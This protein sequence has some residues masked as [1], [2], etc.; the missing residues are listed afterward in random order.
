MKLAV[1]AV[2]LQKPKNMHFT[3]NIFKYVFAYTSMQMHNYPICAIFLKKF[4]VIRFFNVKLFWWW[5]T[6][7]HPPS[8]WTMGNI[9]LQERLSASSIHLSPI[10]SSSEI[11]T[12]TQ[13]MFSW[14]VAGVTFSHG[15]TC[16]WHL[17]LTPQTS[18]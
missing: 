2:K 5:Q 16:L 6:R 7:M 18:F 1:Y 9:R 14:I 10:R 17:I 15:G 3:E 4:I 8:W 12:W 11:M 13:S